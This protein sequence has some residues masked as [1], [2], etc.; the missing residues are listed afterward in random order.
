[1][2]SPRKRNRKRHGA[3]SKNPIISCESKSRS[4]CSK[5]FPYQERYAGIGLPQLNGEFTWASGGFLSWK[6]LKARDTFTEEEKETCR[7][8]GQ[9]TLEQAFAHPALVGYTWH[10]FCAKATGPEQPGFGLNDEKGTEKRTPGFGEL[11]I[12]K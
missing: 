9:T 2:R 3:A 6:K 1:L 10:K 8:R 5:T 11:G 7:R 4:R 12:V